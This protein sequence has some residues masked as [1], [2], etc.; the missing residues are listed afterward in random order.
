[1]A[2]ASIE[3]PKGHPVASDTNLPFS[4]SHHSNSWLQCISRPKGALSSGIRRIR[5]NPSWAIRCAFITQW[6]VSI[7]F[8]TTTRWPDT[9]PV[10]DEESNFGKTA[11]FCKVATLMA[12]NRVLAFHKITPQEIAIQK[13]SKSEDE[14]SMPKI[15]FSRRNFDTCNRDEK[16]FFTITVS[17][18]IS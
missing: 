6:Q 17:D 10:G 16:G 9:Y 11:A 2:A 7:S 18:T 14:E 3:A 5:H 12:F 13:R 1:M 15:V 8:M 4:T